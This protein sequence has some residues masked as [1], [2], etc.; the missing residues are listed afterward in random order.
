MKIVHCGNYDFLKYGKNFYCPDYKI[1]DGLIQNGW[2]VYPYSYRDEARKNIFNSK[3]FGIKK[4]NEKLIEITKNVRPDILLLGHSELVENVTLEILKEKF[5]KMKIA[6]WWVDPFK[7]HSHIL[8]RMKILDAFFAT[9]GKN[10]LKKIFQGNEEKL[11]FFPNL[12]NPIIENGKAY[13]HENFLYD[14][15]Y[16]GRSSSDRDNFINNLKKIND[17]KFGHFGQNR[18]NLIYGAN[19][20]DVLSSGKIG[21]NLSRYNDIELYSSDRIIQLTANGLL[22]MS[23]KIPKFEYLFNENEIVYF[24]DFNDFKE[25]VIFYLKNDNIRKKI[26]IKNILKY[27][28]KYYILIL[29]SGKI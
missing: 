1:H 7:N 22:T 12:S 21:L 14:I 16:I 15:V 23:P 3:K 18:E 10:E 24:D 11:Y 13:E 27:I 29:I 5:P 4:V 9:T 8:Q 6:M 2:Y 19:F 26:A 17:I 28:S 25:K 20:F